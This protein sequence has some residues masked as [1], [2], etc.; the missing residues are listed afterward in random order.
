M[1]ASYAPLSNWAD[2]LPLLLCKH[3]RGKE[4]IASK[5]KKKKRVAKGGMASQSAQRH[6]RVGELKCHVQV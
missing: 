4:S 3:S 6:P 1:Y 2:A 5:N